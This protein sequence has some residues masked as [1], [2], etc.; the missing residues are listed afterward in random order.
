MARLFPG[1]DPF[2]EAQ[3]YWP[4]FHSSAITYCR[5]A[6]A[7]QLPDAY[8]VWIEERIQLVE[9]PTEGVKQMMPDLLVDR[10]AGFSEFNRGPAVL[11]VEPTTLTV[12]LLDDVREGYL[13]ILHRPDQTL[14]TVVEL[15]SPD[16]KTGPGSVQY[17]SK[18]NAL[19]YQ[20]VHLVELDFLV[21]GHRL[22][23]VQT[24]PRG[25]AYA[26]V[27]RGDR[28]PDCDVYAWSIRQP[29]SKILIPLLAPDPDIPLD[30]AAVYATTFEKGRYA[31]SI[32]YD[33]PL[34]VPLAP[35]D[36]AWAE[37]RAKGLDR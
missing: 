16:N 14:V 4:G 2:I 8:D 28:R 32:K 21:G 33:R 5:D 7:D 13:K 9:Y 3:N 10:A 24:L 17:L 23:T 26:F 20:P 34:T 27:A 30:L 11:E 31:R 36:R 25:D 19:L 37:A 1:I 15:L 29:L 35:D 22:P 6:I 18:R 12:T